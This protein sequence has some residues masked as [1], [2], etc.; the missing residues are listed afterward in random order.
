M[1][2]QL[3]NWQ[4]AMRIW[5]P[6]PIPQK[7]PN[8]QLAVFIAQ[9][10]QIKPPHSTTFDATVQDEQTPPEPPDH[11]PLPAAPGRLPHPCPKRTCQPQS[12]NRKP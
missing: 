12:V 9:L 8:E 10:V 6:M 7:P 1:K 3:R 4:P 11:N 5:R 2:Q